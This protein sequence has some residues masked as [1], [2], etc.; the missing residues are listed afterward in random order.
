MTE[1]AHTTIAPATASRRAVLTGIAAV[2]LAAV[3]FASSAMETFTKLPDFEANKAEIGQRLRALNLQTDDPHALT[4]AVKA[5][6]A[7]VVLPKLS[8]TNHAQTL[9][10]LKQ[11]AVAQVETATGTAPASVPRPKNPAELAKFMRQRAT[12]AR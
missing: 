3:P 6:Y 11:K 10:S 5:I 12:S 8:Q 1:E 9:A 4:L 7:D 2:P